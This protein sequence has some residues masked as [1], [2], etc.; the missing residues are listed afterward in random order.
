[1]VPVALTTVVAVGCA[2]DGSP[3]TA[4]SLGGSTDALAGT[5]TVSAA[6]SLADAFTSIGSDFMAA[7]PGV[8]V[9]F[10]FDAS[11]VLATQVLEG[12]DADVYASADEASMS[13]LTESDL[14][15]G[16]VSVVARNE[17]VI[18]TQP[19]NP[20]GITGLA[21]LADAGVV[22]LCGE[23]VPCGRYA[24]QVL[25]DAGVSIPEGNVTRGQNVT[26]TLTA[27]SQGDAD[28]AIVY[29]SD[30]VRA[31]DA[32]EAVTIPTEQNVI[33]VYPMGVVGAS[34]N[35]RVAEAFV[36]HVL[37]P[38]GQAVLE[39]FGFLPAP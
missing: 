16:E 3:S 35:P 18:V 9:R 13:R 12:A 28:A 23:Q 25:A 11:S 21:D 38:E 20:E 37:S 8:E 36:V 10:N 31:G 32:I 4:T 7:N 33:A 6:A 5:I 17:L 1:M 15:A 39:E 34:G 26:A 29:S 30:A 24:D 19:G 27:V 2:R 14:I 22:S